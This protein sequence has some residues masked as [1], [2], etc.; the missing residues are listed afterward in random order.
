MLKK[1]KNNLKRLEEVNLELEERERDL[2]VTQETAE[3][4]IEA[5]EI[6]VWDWHIESG[7]LHW[8]SWM[9]KMFGY[10]DERIEA[11]FDHF[12]E[13]VHQDDRIKVMDSIEHCRTTSEPYVTTYRTI[14]D[15]VI[16][17][18]GRWVVADGLHIRM[19][20]VCFSVGE[21]SV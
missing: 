18:R 8:N 17:A 13:R 10:G 3:L 21:F 15:D 2:L 5:G 4:A 14:T 7:E 11:T 16:Y 1:Q 19:I 12:I 9:F 6:G 20:G